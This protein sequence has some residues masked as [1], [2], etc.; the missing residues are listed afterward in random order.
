MKHCHYFRCAMNES[1]SIQQAAAQPLFLCPVCLRKLRKALKFSVL[2]R[3]QR[4]LRLCREL[5]QEVLDSY[6]HAEPIKE[7][8]GVGVH[9]KTT[10]RLTQVGSHSEER[11]TSKRE[12]TLPTCDARVCPVSEEDEVID[13]SMPQVGTPPLSTGA[14][15]V[16]HT[17]NQN[18]CVNSGA[19][20]STL[21][22][23]CQESKSCI[24]TESRI[25]S[26]EERSILEVTNSIPCASYSLRHVSGSCDGSTTPEHQLR[27]FREAIVWLEQ[28]TADA[29]AF[30]QR[31]PSALRPKRN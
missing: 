24:V 29:T 31:Y 20:S 4:M 5:Y 30:T 21:I 2:E 8:S 22:P 7:D 6:C 17:G 14:P 26:D 25:C 13:C 16:S 15:N 3:Y 18:E 23:T 11:V 19:A 27:L 9:Y 28:S 10:E 12:Q 1:S